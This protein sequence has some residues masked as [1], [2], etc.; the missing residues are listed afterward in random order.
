MAIDG[1]D[2]ISS[3]HYGA[4]G[5]PHEQW[6]ELRSQPLTYFEP[7]GYEPFWAVTR[8]A[9]IQEISGRP[10]D[11]CN[12]EG[13]V[14]LTQEQIDERETSD[15]P[16]LMKTI[17]EMDPP[18]HRMFRKVAS[19][20]FTP[21]GIERLDEIVTES[22]KTVID[23]LGSE[24]EADFVEKITQQHPLRVL[25]TILGIEPDQEAKLLEL[26]T[27]LFGGEDPELQR[28]AEN[29]SDA[30]LALFMDFFTMFND[31][32][33]DRRANPRDD[34]ATMLATA[35]LENGEPLGDMETLGYYLI[36]FN[37]GHDTTRHSLTGAFQAFLNNPGEL[38]RI[39]DDPSLVK[40][41]VEE[42]VRYS[43]PVNYMKRTATRDLIYD[44]HE[45]KKGDMF[46]LFYASANR[47]AEVFED[48]DRFDVGR[49]PN[50]HLGFGW[51]EHYC[52]GAHLARASIHALIEELAA[53]MEWMELAGTPDY[54]ASSF[55]VG[56]KH[57]PV[58]YKVSA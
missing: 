30:M 7:D 1:L 45:I 17:I 53:R 50:R 57:L 58:R 35:T 55:V 54:V 56:P 18:D 42:V 31:I 4:A 11:F 19:G 40:S 14:I 23:S 39:R 16:M 28:E 38:R 25:S 15:I 8:H 2:L 36:I 22:A 26:T 37:A 3:A 34:L 33:Q 13:I 27:Q 41:A 44:G 47:D 5:P 52:L 10:E 46:G 48:P 32:I 20:F 51:A 49:H 9:D 29:R 6:R 21:R 24:G 43:A 12:G